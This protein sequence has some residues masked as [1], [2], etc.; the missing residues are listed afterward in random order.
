M[1]EQTN[2]FEVDN[3]GR[4]ATRLGLSHEY[5]IVVQILEAAKRLHVSLGMYQ[6]GIVDCEMKRLS[7]GDRATELTR[8]WSDTYISFESLGS[9]LKKWQPI[10]DA[11]ES[12]IRAEVAAEKQQVAEAQNGKV[13][14]EKLAATSPAHAQDRLALVVIKI[15][16]VPQQTADQ[17]RLAVIDRAAGQQPQSRR[18]QK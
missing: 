11:I 15:G 10:D 17:R 4:K 8:L 1:A 3:T 13:G 9:L 2:I 12:A 18:H 14:L 16:S 6:I 7:A 5:E